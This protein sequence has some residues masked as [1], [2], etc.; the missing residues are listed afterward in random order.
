MAD[1]DSR[2]PTTGRTAAEEA[3]FQA[4]TGMPSN[5]PHPSAPPPGNGPGGAGKPPPV[6]TKP[7]APGVYGAPIGDTILK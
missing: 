5:P 4:G 3:D 7:S 2:N 6:N 1:H